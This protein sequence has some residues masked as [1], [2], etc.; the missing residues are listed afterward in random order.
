MLARASRLAGAAASRWF[1]TVYTAAPAEAEEMFNE[2]WMKVVPNFDPPKI[3]LS[4]I[5][6]SPPIPTSIPS[7]LTLN[8]H[9]PYS[10]HLSNKQV[11]MVIVPAITGQ[12]GV[13]PGHAATMT[14]L[15]P[16]I[17]SLQ[18]GNEITKYFVCGGFAFIH[19]NSVA[20]I[21]TVEAV[22][23][24]IIDPNMVQKGLA[25]FSQKLNSATTDYEK[26]EA[27]I[28]VDVHNALQSALKG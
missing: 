27:Q 28:G 17:L 23:L 26:I 16:G 5:Q 7:K 10:S 21:I 11:D 25:E 4:F 22:P 24:D 14:E 19:P 6:P 13:F 9:L 15:K 1:S 12:M 8:F 2:A 3:P 18:E 20:D